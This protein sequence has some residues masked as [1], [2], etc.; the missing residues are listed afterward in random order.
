[1]SRSRAGARAVI[2]L[3]FLC[4][5]TRLLSGCDAAAPDEVQ[6]ADEQA[7]D[8]DERAP[9][10]QVLDAAT[11]APV[12]AL[13]AGATAGEEVVTDQRFPGLRPEFL[14]YFWSNVDAARFTAWHPS[15]KSFAWKTPPKVPGDL[16]A[17]PGASYEARIELASGAH[18]LTVTYIDPA[19]PGVGATLES[20]MAADVTID[21]AGPFRLVVEYAQEGED[22]HV[23]QRL[24]LPPGA[25]RAG[26]KA[27]LEERMTKLASFIKTPFQR[28][29]VDVE[30]TRR[31]TVEIVQ[32][33][34]ELDLVVKQAIGKVT[35]DM[36][37]W[38]WDNMGET[39]R[40][41]HWHPT[42]HKKFTWTTPPKNPRDLRYDPG[43]MQQVVEQIGEGDATLNIGWADP[44]TV[45]VPLTYKNYLY[46]TTNLNGTPLGGSLLHEYEARDGGIVMKSTFRLSSLTPMQFLQDLGRH[47]IQEMQFLQYYLP[48]LYAKE[49]RPD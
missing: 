45:K 28:E 10:A 17:E 27:Y 7:N 41:R 14:D 3:S 8:G 46:G 1:M 49:Y 31:G 12:R 19:T 38:W 32:Q 44:K 15:H 21:G 20:A 16:G 37:D 33:G 5:A 23:K 25:D 48:R 29:Y 43:S 40:Y 6:R 35:T 24:A 11:S 47:C 30:L 2:H 4:A 9:R 13:D 22:V 36:V 42:A 34:A 39:E 18:A 26:V